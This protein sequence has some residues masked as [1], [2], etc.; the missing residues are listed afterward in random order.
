MG[1]RGTIIHNPRSN[2][3]NA[4]GYGDP[5][6]FADPVAL[7][8][9]GIGADMLDEFRLAY[10]RHREHDVTASPESAWGWLA[11]GWELFPEALADRVTWTYPVMDPWRLAFSPGVSPITVEI[12]GEVVWADGAPTRVDADEI[13][14]RAAGAAHDLFRRLEELP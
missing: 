2:M 13:R 3:N 12:G 6:R 11:T 1:S 10:V 14:A 7:G 4:V 9:D 8:T 5:S